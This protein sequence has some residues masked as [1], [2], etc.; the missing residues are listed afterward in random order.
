MPK[1]V[2]QSCG[3]SFSSKKELKDHVEDQHGGKRVLHDS[4]ESSFDFNPKQAVNTLKDTFKNKKKRYALIALLGALLLIGS[5]FFGSFASFGSSAS[6]YNSSA[7]TNPPT[8]Y[9]LQRPPSVNNL[10]DKISS[11]PLDVE[12]QLAIL[13]R[14]GPSDYPGILL[15]YN[16]ANCSS[17]VSN[18][19]AIAQEFDPWVYVAPY[20]EMEGGLALSAWRNLKKMDS[21]DRSEIKEFICDNLNNQPVSCAF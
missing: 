5:S 17:L 15:Q 14:G 7:D 4:E 20:S 8:G 10:P 13:L 9:G 6:G 12:V 1:F 21:Y 11:Q 18:L 3:K 16:C 2:C 19:T